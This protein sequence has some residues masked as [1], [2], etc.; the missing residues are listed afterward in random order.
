MDEYSKQIADLRVLRD[1]LMKMNLPKSADVAHSAIVSIE[2]LIAE[3]D[4]ALAAAKTAKLEGFR[5]ARD[6]AAKITGMM[7][8]DGL[9]G[10]KTAILSMKE[11]TE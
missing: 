9:L 2:A 10:C 5:R 3:R 7:P 4:A 11:P 1:L 6:E 8:C